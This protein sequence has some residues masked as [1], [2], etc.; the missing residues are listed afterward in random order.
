MKL[1]RIFLPWMNTCF[2]MKHSDPVPALHFPRFQ[3]SLPKYFLEIHML[4]NT[5]L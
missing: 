2:T 4:M 1:G 3:S 5:I